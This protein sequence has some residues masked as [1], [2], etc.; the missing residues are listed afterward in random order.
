MTDSQYGTVCGQVIRTLFGA[1]EHIAPA[2]AGRIA[3]ELFCPTSNPRQLGERETKAV[4][5]A[6]GL[7]ADARKH[8]LTT[9]T[10]NVTAFEFRP[11][12]GRQGWAPC[13]S[14]MA[15]ARA[16]NT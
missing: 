7:L 15:G 11:L 4:A 13:L 2:L 3:F 10:G 14:S 1:G 9:R 5:R 8:C 12:I 16:P 6:A